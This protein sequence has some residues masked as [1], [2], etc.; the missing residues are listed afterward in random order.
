[1]CLDATGAN[2][3]TPP[4]TAS[5]IQL[6]PCNQSPTKPSQAWMRYPDGSLFDAES[7]N[8]MRAVNGILQL[9][10]SIN[11]YHNLLIET[12]KRF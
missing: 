11:D 3:L 1:M 2:A 9:G 6:T 5:P 4:S 10:Y 12:K 7:N 8:C